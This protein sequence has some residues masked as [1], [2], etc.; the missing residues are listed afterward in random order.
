[1]VGLRGDTFFMQVLSTHVEKF[2][3]PELEKLGYS[4]V[5]K[6]KSGDVR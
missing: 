5:Y 2:F 1:M 4:G 6:K 3:T